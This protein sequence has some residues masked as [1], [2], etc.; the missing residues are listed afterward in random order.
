MKLTVLGSCGSYPGPGRACSGYLVETTG[1]RI[2]IDAGSGTLANLQRHIDPA[3]VSAVVLT[4][5]HPDHW[6]DITGYH[7]AAKYDLGL[8]SVPIYAP[9]PVRR[10]AGRM[11]APFEWNDVE[12][13]DSVRIGDVQAS[14]SRTDHPVETLAVRVEGGG[15]RLGYSAD[16]GPGW[17]LR[18]LGDD[19]EVALCEATWLE[20]REGSGHMSA[21]QA[22]ESAREAGAGRLILTHLHPRT[23]VA[24]ALEDARDVFGPLVEIARDGD[25]FEV[26][27]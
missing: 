9:A 22:A 15:A 13:G 19:L 23:D 10:R 24:R 8:E 2:W 25:V 17:R 6:V 3:T 1:S 20:E 16:S 14:F 26:G 5:E 12:G 4:H 21:A 11:G 7:V 18:E 27:E